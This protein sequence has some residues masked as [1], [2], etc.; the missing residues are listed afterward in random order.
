M[1]A[2]TR[3]AGRVRA[4]GS[5]NSVKLLVGPAVVAAAVWTDDIISAFS[6]AVGVIDPVPGEVP[7]FELATA[8]PSSGA[9]MSHPDHSLTTAPLNVLVVPVMLTVIAANAPLTFF[10][11]QISAHRAVLLRPAS[12]HVA[13]VCEMLVIWPDV[14]VA[15]QHNTRMFP[16]VGLAPSVMETVVPL[17]H[18]APAC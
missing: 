14:E 5:V 1:E 13:P 10:A 17:D 3:Y 12:T 15:P 18:A 6:D 2:T 16:L 9:V 4:L 7:V 11:Y 8:E